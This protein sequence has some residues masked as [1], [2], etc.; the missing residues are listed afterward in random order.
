M[1]AERCAAGGARGCPERTR[2]PG[3]SA[4]RNRDAGAEAREVEDEEA[5]AYAGRE[6][7][8]EEAR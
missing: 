3:G 4:L 2:K 5:P 7:M 6:V 8:G 1:G